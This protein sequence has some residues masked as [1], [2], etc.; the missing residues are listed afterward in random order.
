MRVGEHASQ[1]ADPHRLGAVRHHADDAFADADLGADP[2]ARI[3][4]ARDGEEPLAVFVDE[5]QERMLVPEQL[6]EARQ[7]GADER[8][9]VRATGQTLAEL[10]ELPDLLAIGPQLAGHR[11]ATCTAASTC[12]I[13]TT[14]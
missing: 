14:R 12:S 9:E 11:S 6:V 10:R 8:V 7:R 3:A 1:V 4:A 2:F 5:E 13:S